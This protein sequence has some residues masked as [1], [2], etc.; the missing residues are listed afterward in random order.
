MWRIVVLLGLLWAVP[1]E[2]TV[3]LEAISEAT[4]G[5]GDLSWSHGGTSPKGVIV[6]VVQDSNSATDEV[7]SVTYGSL[8]LT[9]IPGSPN[10]SSG[11]ENGVAYAYFAGSAIPTVSQTVTV[12]VSGSSSK[13]AYAISI[14][15]ATYTEV[16]SSD[17]TLDTTNCSSCSVTLPL[18]GR[19][20]FAAIGFVS[21]E[22]DPASNTPL[23]NWSADDTA[24]EHDF[25]NQTAGAYTYNTIGSS[26]V[27]CGWTQSSDDAL[28]MCVAVSEIRPRRMTARD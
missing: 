22:N 7:S 14:A 10:T 5:T 13:I 2:A 28:A 12:T 27:T 15:A 19:T 4:A 25:G 16:V 1:A 24:H 21:G 3:S 26:D 17:G 18:G 20:S 23:T 8:T 6:F 11:G 9:E